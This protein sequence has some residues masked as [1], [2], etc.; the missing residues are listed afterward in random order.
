MPADIPAPG[1]QGSSENPFTLPT[2]VIS[3]AGAG[4]AAGTALFPGIGTIVGGAIGGLGSLFSGLFGQSSA[5]EQMRFQE[6]MS[7]TAHQREVA[8]LRAAGLNPMLSARHGGASA[9]QG[10]SATMPNPGS[11]LGAGVSAS[12]RMMGIE[13]PALESQIRQQ[14]A[15][16]EA[17]YGQAESARASAV[18]S[19]TEANSKTYDNDLKRITAE[20]IRQLTKPE[21]GETLAHAALMREQLHVQQASAKQLAE[22]AARTRAEA[23]NARARL[24][25]LEWESSPAGIGLDAVGKAANAIGDLHPAGSVGKAIFGGPSSAKRIQSSINSMKG[26]R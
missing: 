24:G 4:A 13:L 25:R 5:R 19:L 12:A 3:S 16:S 7:N 22:E 26:K 14:A 9:P 6:R 8:D 11:D 2:Q 18:L 23:A 17:A 21:V 10:Q 20:R 15:Q 1:E